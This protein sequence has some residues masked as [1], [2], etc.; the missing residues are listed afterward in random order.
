MNDK[1]QVESILND[2]R[3]MVNNV[4]IKLSYQADMYETTDIKR[5]AD[6]YIAAYL[7][8]DTFDSYR[9]Y[10]MEVIAKAGISNL[11]DLTAYSSDRNKIPREKRK[12]VLKA[13][14]ETVIR[15]YV[16]MND[17]Y[18]E[19]IG[20]PS[21]NT[22][23]EE[24]IYLTEEEMKYYEIDE[25]RPIHDYPKEIL[26]KLE[27]DL[28]PNLIKLYPE[29]TYLQHMGSKAVNLVRARQA[30][31]F[32]IIFT[33][34]KLDTVFMRAFFETYDFAREY[35]MGLIYN[36]AF[37]ERYDLYD[38]YMGMHIMIMTVQRLVVDTIKMG[39]DRDFYDLISIKKLFN[40][41]GVPFFEDLPLDY[42]RTIV[43]NVNMLIRS[44][45]TDKV[46]YD[47]ANTLFYERVRIY[48]YFLV[49]ERK[50]DEDGN[51][52]FLYKEEI[53]DTPPEKYYIK[54]NNKKTYELAVQGKHLVTIECQV[55]YAPEAIYMK[56]EVTGEMFKLFMIDDVIVSK[57]V[58]DKNQI[59]Q[60]VIMYNENF[61]KF[62]LAVDKDVIETEEIDYNRVTVYDYEHMY[63]VYFQATDIM[64][65]N[66][67]STLETK[68]NRYAYDEVVKDDVYW[69]ET[70]E[71]KK[72]LFGR[73]YT[74]I[75]TKYISVTVMQNL[76]KMLY[77]TVY[78]LNMLVDHKNTTVPMLE[79]VFNSDAMKYGTDYL[80]LD[81]DRFTTVPVSIFDSVMILCALVAKKNGMKGN[82]IVESP[83]KIL[84]VL[85][86]NF[87]A[88]FE[89]I[90]ENIRKYKRVFKNQ[91]I[92]KYLDLLDIRSV[93]DIDTLFNNFKNFAEFCA[94]VVATT[95]DIN[96]YKAYKELYKVITVRKDATKLFTM[97]DGNVANTYLEYLYDKLPVIADFIDNMHKDKTGVFI[98]HVLGKLNELIPEIEYLN[99]INGTNNNI[100]QAILG[101]INFFKSYT[102]D[103]RT[104]NILYMFDNRMLNKIYMI[105]DPRLFVTLYPTES[106][107]LY[108]DSLRP[109]VMFDKQDNLVIYD[110][111]RLGTRL[112]PSDS[113]G[114]YDEIEQLLIQLG[115]E[116]ELVLSYKDMMEM[117]NNQSID[118]II[119]LRE[120]NALSTRLIADKDKFVSKHTLILKNLL[121]ILDSLELEY[122]D[123]IGNS[124]VIFTKMSQLKLKIQ[125]EFL[126]N[127]DSYED[128]RPR[129]G[130]SIGI[131]KEA[132][133]SLLLDYKDVIK[134]LSNII[135]EELK[136][137]LIETDL[138][139]IS[140]Q[141]IDKLTDKDKYDTCVGL[142]K[143]DT[144]ELL[145]NDNI[146][147]LKGNMKL[148]NA[149]I[150][151]N[152]SVKVTY[153]D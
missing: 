130:Y 49:R 122:K 142:G 9:A 103:L 46:L 99:T 65:R 82:I 100:V 133:D 84:S 43:K 86:F 32:D 91:E 56:D 141:G 112:R 50:F 124:H 137:N 26:H 72:E 63:D 54:S 59:C 153:E 145:Y 25:V 47:I 78:Y 89:L 14:R 106:Y 88:N 51:P 13:M 136:L 144:V 135:C 33:D 146:D 134:D 55:P 75:D 79:R 76:T 97:S 70:E 10:P 139:F 80:Y 121:T 96:E 113:A 66:V 31:N 115:V 1:S 120:S 30:R 77:E 42:Q 108:A 93:K 48:K 104:L 36:K 64:E 95:T 35:F 6:R 73:D 4:I 127:I 16:E 52:I 5:E 69:W 92:L 143:D 109:T 57:P 27:R 138:T 131:G 71:L 90:R 117:I 8:K 68:Y 7:E 81:L 118:A 60:S 38:N 125:H 20:M 98:E 148:S 129:D 22:P 67:I 11:N 29:R 149:D 24:W 128:W 45:S 58:E 41:Y 61:E 34:I 85:G 19:L 105:D 116:D 74:Y 147:M 126:I 17:Y 12:D 28:I 53:K 15:E 37:K 119:D 87:E 111:S 152:D 102:V 101:L 110:P 3:S 132:I 62:K 39:I 140:Q 23:E 114:M 18:R 2:I 40:V 151:I 150:Y 83:S 107:P 123:L 94:D 44:K 21:I